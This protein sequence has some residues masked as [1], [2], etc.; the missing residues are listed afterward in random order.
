[1]RVRFPWLTP[2]RFIKKEKSGTETRRCRYAH[3]SSMFCLAMWPTGKKTFTKCTFWNV[4]LQTISW[5]ISYKS[6]I[7]TISFFSSRTDWNR[8]PSEH[9]PSAR[10]SLLSWRYS[11][12]IPASTYSANH[13]QILCQVLDKTGFDVFPTTTLRSRFYY[14]IKRGTWGM[15]SWDN[16]PGVSKWRIETL[17]LILFVTDI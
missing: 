2:G 3:A 14:P 10:I 16:Q 8:E 4:N 13:C 5:T 9:S 1:M 17:C 7:S 15:K 11:P 6:P 12:T